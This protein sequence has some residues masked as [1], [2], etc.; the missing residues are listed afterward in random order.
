MKLGDGTSDTSQGE[1]Q[2]KGCVPGEQPGPSLN[3]V[4]LHP[5]LGIGGAERL[6]VDAGLALIRRGHSVT[7]VTGHHDKSHCFEETRFASFAELLLKYIHAHIDA[8][9]KLAMLARRRW[10]CCND[11]GQIC[12]ANTFQM[13]IFQ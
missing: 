7:Y 6:V 8:C 10:S 3:V 13:L 11:V 9:C 12:K 2:K 4:F 5:D 1:H